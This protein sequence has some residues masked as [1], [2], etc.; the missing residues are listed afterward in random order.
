VADL[1]RGDKVRIIQNRELGE[2]DDVYTDK[3]LLIQNGIIW[4]SRTAPEL[5]LV[6]E[7]ARIRL[8]EERPKGWG[9]FFSLMIEDDRV[10]G[11]AVRDDGQVWIA[12]NQI[13]GPWS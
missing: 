11:I 1:K 6:T 3:I 12:G 8:V 10:A 13:R 5:E 9:R 7:P 2:F 4:G